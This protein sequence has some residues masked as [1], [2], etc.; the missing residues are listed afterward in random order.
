[1]RCKMVWVQGR[2]P[3]RRLRHLKG[4]SNYKPM[5]F[6]RHSRNI[7]GNVFPEYRRSAWGQ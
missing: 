2:E 7:N 4:E 1:M 3:A 6:S 5:E